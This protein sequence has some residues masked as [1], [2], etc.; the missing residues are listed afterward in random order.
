MFK[1]YARATGRDAKGRQLYRIPVR[2]I[3]NNSAGSVPVSA[4]LF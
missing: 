4:A 3:F 1:R 2:V